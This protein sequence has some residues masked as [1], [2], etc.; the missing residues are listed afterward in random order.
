MTRALLVLLLC[1]CPTKKSG[2]EENRDPYR[3]VTPE[4]VKAKVENSLKQ[5]DQRNDERLKELK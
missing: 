1:G 5:E 2:P 4:K 3:E